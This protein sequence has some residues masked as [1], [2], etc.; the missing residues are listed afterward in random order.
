MCTETR[1]RAQE[2]RHA[3][4][5]MSSGSFGIVLQVVLIKSTKKKVC[6]RVLAAARR[7]PP[8]PTAARRSARHDRREPTLIFLRAVACSTQL[9]A[10]NATLLRVVWHVLGFRYLVIKRCLL[11]VSD[12]NLS[13]FRRRPPFAWLLLCIRKSVVFVQSAGVVVC[14]SMFEVC[15]CVCELRVVCVVCGARERAHDACVPCY[16]PYYA[17]VGV[18]CFRGHKRTRLK[19]F[20]VASRPPER[21]LSRG[22]GCARP[23]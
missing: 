2:Q 19:A 15:G 14:V 22:A 13:R 6:L 8:Q 23:A 20:E 12:L 3:W 10:N 7:S 18:L 9:D 21:E 4:N 11:Y 1:D 5:F 16:M 17:I